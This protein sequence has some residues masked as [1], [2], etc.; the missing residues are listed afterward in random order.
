VPHAGVEVL[1]QLPSVPAGGDQAHESGEASALEAATVAQAVPPAIHP[2]QPLHAQSAAAEILAPV[3]T[4]DWSRDLGKTLVWMASGERSAAQIRLNPP[5]LG[6]LEI[7][8]TL[9]AGDG[10]QANVAFASP[11]SAVREAIEAAMPQLRDMLA[12]SGITLGQTT[13][14]AESFRQPG[15]PDGFAASEEASAESVGRVDGTAAAPTV[16][17]GTG[18][19][20]TFA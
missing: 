10:G 8:L 2:A 6:P 16:R 7:K 5:E 17:T 13:V 14:S 19:V 3:H 1:A 4:P 11:H 18:L 15:N 12:G 9:G 20:D